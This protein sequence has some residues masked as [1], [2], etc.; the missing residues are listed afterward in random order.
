MIRAVL[1]DIDG[2]LFDSVK[3]NAAFYRDLFEHF[4]Y[5]LPPAP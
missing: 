3:A 2:V 4:G 1:F 5:H